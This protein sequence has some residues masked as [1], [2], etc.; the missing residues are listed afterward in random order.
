M[1]IPNVYRCDFLSAWFVPCPRVLPPGGRFLVFSQK[2]NSQC[3]PLRFR[4]CVVCPVIWIFLYCGRAPSHSWDVPAR[5]V[6][7][8]HVFAFSLCQGPRFLDIPGPGYPG[9]FLGHPG[10]IPVDPPRKKKPCTTRHPARHGTND[11]PT[12]AEKKSQMSFFAETFSVQGAAEGVAF[13]R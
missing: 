3:I 1:Q 11:P 4:V 10:G 6:S 12:P 8:A 2:A 7:G 9:G 13:L 5:F